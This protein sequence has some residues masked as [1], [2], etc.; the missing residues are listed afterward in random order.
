MSPTL[1]PPPPSHQQHPVDVLPP[2]VGANYPTSLHIPG[3][4]DHTA[5]AFFSASLTQ[6]ADF[7]KRLISMKKEWDRPNGQS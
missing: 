6:R 1:N 7:L 2:F 5:A 3:C 4:N